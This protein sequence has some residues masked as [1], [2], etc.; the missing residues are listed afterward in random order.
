MGALHPAAA[1]RAGPLR[2][3]ISDLFTFGDCGQP[4]CLDGSINAGTGHGDHYLPAV[5]SGNLAIISFISE[6]IG[7]SVARTPISATSSGA[8]FTFVGGI[9]VRNSTSAGPIFAERASTLGRGRVFLG[10]NVSGVNFTT[11]GGTPADRIILNFVH[12]D[13]DP[14]GSLGDPVR[15]ND[16]IRLSME[17]DIRVLVSS[18]FFTYGVTD[19]IDIGLS[20]PFVRTSISG[21]SEAQIEP[22]GTTAVHFFSG[23]IDDPVLSGSASAQ[24]SSAGLGD[25]AARVK[26]NLGQ[27]DKVGVAV[28]AAA[29]FATG[30]EE[31]L[32]GDGSHALRAVGIISGQFG[33]FSPH[34]NAGY[35]M[36]SGELQNDAV[37]ATVGFDQLMAPWATLALELIS[38][39]QV[40]D[41]KISLPGPIEFDAP[42]PRRLE[43]TSIKS[44]RENIVEASAGMKFVVRGGTTIIT[45]AIIPLARV[46]LQPNV[47]WST[48]LEF[49]F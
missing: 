24:G 3:L 5:A 29:R 10:A 9:P 32:L 34:L 23:T 43:A 27:S 39:W 38:E 28:L 19:F 35:L 36:R 30:N 18:L 45:N 1:Q 26:I 25:V 42:F 49:S 47:V 12:Q 2:D 11:I 7:K 20:V 17:L 44:A 33:D 37:L 31:E 16:L 41:N 21:A 22:F 6:A 13:V 4:L 8:T 14:E 46:G 15:E 48:G 40:G